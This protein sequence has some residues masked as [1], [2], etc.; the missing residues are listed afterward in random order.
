MTGTCGTVYPRYLS[1]YSKGMLSSCQQA[2][3]GGRRWAGPCLFLLELP[4]F[5]GAG[6]LHLAE[7]KQAERDA[8]RG[9][10]DRQVPSVAG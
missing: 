9:S 5:C 4:S 10:L 1:N 3:R 7:L 8:R 2:D 6:L